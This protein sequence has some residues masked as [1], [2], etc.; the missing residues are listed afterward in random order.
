MASVTIVCAR[1]TSSNYETDR[2]CAGC[3]LPIGGMQPDAD[4]GLDALGPYEAPDPADPD[5]GRAIHDFL[6][7]SG[8]PLAPA[9]R[10]W[11]TTVALGLDRKQ[12]IYVGPAGVDAE[13]RSLVGFVS[14]CGPAVERDC[15]ILLKLNARMIDGCFAIRVLRGEE[16]FVFVENLP[17][18]LLPP[19]DAAAVLR[20]IAA[21]A[22]GLEDRLSRGR[23]IY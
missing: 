15:R 4:A 7:R 20:R 8:G 22:D 23:D 19:L 21:A 6:T 2:F 13:G 12:A 18:E 10:G 14:V 1:C 16:Y 5:V 17:V 3:G 9:G 11:R